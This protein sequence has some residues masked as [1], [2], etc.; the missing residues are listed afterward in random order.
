MENAISHFE[1]IGAEQA[2]KGFSVK[3]REYN[4][5]EFYIFVTALNDGSLT[6]HGANPKLVG[7]KLGN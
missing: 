2:Y 4:K 3:G 6:F 7:K 1:K 5:G